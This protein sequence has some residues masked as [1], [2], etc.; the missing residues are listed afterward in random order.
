M[1]SDTTHSRRPE[2]VVRIA[3]AADRG[4]ERGLQMRRDV[5]LVPVGSARVLTLP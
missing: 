2:G 5:Q 3:V 4:G 1:N